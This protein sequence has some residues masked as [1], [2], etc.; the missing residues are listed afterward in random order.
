MRIKGKI[1]FWKFVKSS[2]IYMLG[3]GWGAPLDVVVLDRRQE[4]IN[5]I[6]ESYPQI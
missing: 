2:R 5:E 6:E 4:K 3:R 1:S